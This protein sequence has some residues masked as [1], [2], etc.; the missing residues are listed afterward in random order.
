MQLARTAFELGSPGCY[1]LEASLQAFRQ[2][3]AELEMAIHEQGPIGFGVTAVLPDLE[4][5]DIVLEAEPGNVISISAERTVKRTVRCQLNNSKR[6][7]SVL[8]RAVCPPL[9]TAERMVTALAAS[10]RAYSITL[11]AAACSSSPPLQV[12]GAV[13]CPSPTLQL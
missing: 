1:A 11:E 3:A 2:P 6:C 12:E 13:C 8:C 7:C 9:Q 10:S 5:D 4:E